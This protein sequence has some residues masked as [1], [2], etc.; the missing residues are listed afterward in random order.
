MDGKTL[1]T[2]QDFS[3]RVGKTS[4]YSLPVNIAE[5]TQVDYSGLSDA[6]KLVLFLYAYEACTYMG[7]VIFVR[8]IAT[9][10]GW[11]KYKIRKLR[12]QINNSKNCN[13]YIDINTAFSEDTGLIAGKGYALDVYT[14]KN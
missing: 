11:S 9:Y 3:S 7:Y 2:L 1:I 10:F 12:N 14:H 6:E 5:E 8:T 13:Y 4:M